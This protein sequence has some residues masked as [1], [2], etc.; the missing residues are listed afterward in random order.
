[1]PQ[2][3]IRSRS[4]RHPGAL[5]RRSHHSLPDRSPAASLA[6]A[7]TFRLYLSRCALS[8][9][10]PLQTP[11]PSRPCPPPTHRDTLRHALPLSHPPRPSPGS[12]ARPEPLRSPR[13]KSLCV[14]PGASCRISNARALT[15][16]SDGGH[17]RPDRHGLLRRRRILDDRR[18]L[19]TPQPSASRGF[20]RDRDP[21]DQT[22][23]FP[24]AITGSIG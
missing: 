16:A 7:A 12:L 22:A 1:M 18:V 14:T 5:A 23:C 20:L 2:R 21:R 10:A 6:R 13:Y 19:P 8:P 17:S 15:Q 11:A 9:R 3:R 24:G 4:A